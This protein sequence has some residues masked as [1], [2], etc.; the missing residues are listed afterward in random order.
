MIINELKLEDGR[1]LALKELDP[2]DMLDLIE[3]A[4]AAANG[5]SAGAWLGY[6]EMICSV[7]A[8]DNVPVQ[9]PVTK[10][11]IRDLARRIGKAGLISLQLAF[12][13]DVNK[14][15]LVGTAKN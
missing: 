7:T 2:A 9:M 8:I 13:E 4:G 5:P 15:D 12:D 10:D 11:E 1:I 14:S 3:A 6:A